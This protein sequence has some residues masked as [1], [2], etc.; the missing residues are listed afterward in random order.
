MKVKVE[1]L[2]PKFIVKKPFLWSS[3]G[4]CIYLR[5]IEGQDIII[6]P[7]VV[8]DKVGR[9]V[10]YNLTDAEAWM[11]RLMPSTEISLCNEE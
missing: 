5:N 7:R 1:R 10:A 4:G 3:E 6:V 8:D 11:K 9:V 2:V